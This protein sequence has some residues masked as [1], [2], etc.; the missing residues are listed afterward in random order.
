MRILIKDR[1]IV[2]KLEKEPRKIQQRTSQKIQI[3]SKDHL[4]TLILSMN[5]VKKMQISSIKLIRK[6]LQT[7]TV[8][9]LYNT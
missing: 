5:L 6:T 3:L 2:T 8:S 1:T 9:K 4:K 7:S